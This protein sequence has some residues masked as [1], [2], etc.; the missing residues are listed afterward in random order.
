MSPAGLPARHRF[1]TA[2]L[3]DSPECRKPCVLPQR[4][5]GSGA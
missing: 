3:P 1:E 5:C 2:V 4:S